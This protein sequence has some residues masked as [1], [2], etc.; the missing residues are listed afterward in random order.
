[1][2]EQSGKEKIREG[3]NEREMEM[4]EIDRER[5]SER[6]IERGETRRNK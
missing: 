6:V 5:E 4:G 2:L 1:M 3:D